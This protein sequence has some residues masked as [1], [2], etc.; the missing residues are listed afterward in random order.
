MPVVPRGLHVLAYVPQRDVHRAEVGAGQRA[1]ALYY[2]GRAGILHRHAEHYHA[3]RR[4]LG[5]ADPVE[6]PGL[7]EVPAP[8]PV[9]SVW[10]RV[11]VEAGRAR[12]RGQVGREV[13]YRDV[14]I[15]IIVP[16]DVLIAREA[17]LCVG[18]VMEAIEL[19]VV[20]ST[21]GNMLQ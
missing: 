20:I 8:E 10:S 12:R 9:R 17:S 1:R 14:A 19:V 6:A 13:L 5:A 4:Y 18:R 16:Y 3:R 7:L 11:V 2:S 15:A 21:L